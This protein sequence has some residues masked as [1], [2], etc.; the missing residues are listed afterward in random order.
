MYFITN[1]QTIL[2]F[3][4][5]TILIGFTSAC[6][7]ATTA[8]STDDASTSGTDA[9]AG[10]GAANGS[11]GGT[12][13]NFWIDQKSESKMCSFLDAF[14][15]LKNAE[16]GTTC[17]TIASGTVANCSVSANT[18]TLTYSNCS[19]SSSAAVWNGTQFVAFTGATPVCGS[20]FPSAMS[21]V[22]R[23]FSLGTSRTSAAGVGVIIDTTGAATAADG[24]VYSGGTTVSFSGGLRTQIAIAGLNLNSTR[25]RHTVTTNAG[26]SPLV[27]SNGNTITSGTVITFHN[28]A[29]L[30][31]SSSFTNVA[32]KAGCCTPTSGTITT[33]FS[34]IS[35]V[36]PSTLGA[37]M[38]GTTETLV[39]TGC[40]TANYEGL[41]GTNG[42][43]SLGHCF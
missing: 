12:L 21:S 34:T 1:F 41:D 32:F 11:S 16:A 19:Y 15:P 5:L 40:G 20:A 14:L 22:T 17:P 6:G 3:L 24:N 29:H 9:A 7:K 18:A 35:G 2:S 33:T 42:L 23:T 4:S 13:A 25:F 38:N 28:L 31:A 36:T 8:A 26:G 37:K 43:V 39:F 27:I 10:G 30:K